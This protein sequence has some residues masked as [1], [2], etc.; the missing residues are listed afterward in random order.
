MAQILVTKPGVLDSR[1]KSKLRRA[2]IV[3]VEADNPSDVKLIDPAGGEIG[4]E[5]LLYAA[6][7][8]I[9][10]DTYSV[11]SVFARVMLDEMERV[12]AERAD[13]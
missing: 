6:L 4:H 13:A 11:R 7:K 9:N 5:G 12:R 10:A 1:D 8:A 2:G 3:T